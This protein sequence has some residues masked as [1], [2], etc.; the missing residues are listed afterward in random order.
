MVE[1]TKTHSTVVILTM[2]IQVSKLKQIKHAGV[3]LHPYYVTLFSKTCQKLLFVI[4]FPQ[5][6]AKFLDWR[7]TVLDF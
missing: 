3:M 1:W 5:G 4:G 2:W 6:L 7:C